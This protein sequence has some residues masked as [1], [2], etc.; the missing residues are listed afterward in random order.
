[1]AYMSN[2]PSFPQSVVCLLR[3]DFGGFPEWDT[4]GQNWFPL[5]GKWSSL[6][7][8]TAGTQSGLTK[9]GRVVDTWLAQDGPTEHGNV[10]VSV[11]DRSSLGFVLHPTKSS[12]CEQKLDT[13]K[14]LMKGDYHVGRGNRQRG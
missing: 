4:G 6:P 9:C 2:S 7:R 14:S 13:V 3:T 5:S 11:A 8:T 10:A 1:M 12:C